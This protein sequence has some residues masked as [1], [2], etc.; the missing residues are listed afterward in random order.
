MKFLAL[1]AAL[2][3]YLVLGQWKQALPRQWHVVLGDWEQA[4]DTAIEFV[5]LGDWEQALDTAMELE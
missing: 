3:E 2:M 4:L 5:V 1:E